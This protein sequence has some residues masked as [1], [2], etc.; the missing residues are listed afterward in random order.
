MSSKASLLSPQ[1]VDGTNLTLVDIPPKGGC[2]VLFTSVSP[3][4]R[5]VPDT[6]SWK[7]NVASYLLKCTCHWQQ[8]QDAQ[9]MPSHFHL[10]SRNLNERMVE[11][12][13]DRLKLHRKD[14]QLSF[15]KNQPV[16]LFLFCQ[17]WKGVWPSLH[18]DRGRKKC[19]HGVY[20]LREWCVPAR[21]LSTPLL[22]SF[23]S[24]KQ[25]WETIEETSI[26][27]PS[28]LFL[29]SP[30]RIAMDSAPQWLFRLNIGP[31]IG[32]LHV[33]NLPS[34]NVLCMNRQ[35]K[36]NVCGMSAVP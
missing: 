4:P 6:G 26:K 15:W 11:I 5:I 12:W 17:L 27:S 13:F 24:E 30:D 23:F 8:C 34:E 9:S 3:E 36:D 18:C 33:L 1:P 31:Q 25:T 22:S 2:S 20:H 29:P 28:L 35:A 7:G 21:C 19:E 14:P 16:P 10:A 32:C